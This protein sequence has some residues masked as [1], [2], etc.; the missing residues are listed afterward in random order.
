MWTP[1]S[2]D[3]IRAAVEAGDLTETSRFDAKEALPTGKKTRD[4]ATDV[5][6]M[7][8]DGGTLLYGVGEDENKALRILK[9][10][11]L[12]G[13]SER[14]DQIVRTS[15]VEPP[16]IEVRQIPTTTDPSVGYLVV[17]VPA[18]PRAPHMVVVNKD[19][20][21]YGRSAAGN[22]RLT[23]GEVAR[24]YERR[25]RWEVDRDAMLDEAVGSAPIEPSEEHAYLHLVVRPVT[26][27]EDLFDRARGEQSPERFLDG[28]I[29]RATK[30]EV[31]SGRYSPDLWSNATY[32]RRADGW[33]TSRGLAREWYDLEDPG[34]VLDLE[35]GLDG[36]GRLFCGRAADTY[37]G[38]LLVFETIVAGLATRFLAVM[39][40][41]YAYGAYLGQVDAGLAVTNLRD[42]TSYVLSQRMGL[43]PNPYNKEEY[44]RTAR[45][46][47][48][49]LREQHRDAAREL[50]MPLARALTRESHDPFAE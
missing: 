2:E 30:R 48:S 37:D 25:Q 27:H 5:A 17:S 19:H 42:G 10:F 16:S 20:R 31:F 13:A 3:Q 21:F 7:A 8:N 29:A 9:P 36:R 1:S 45:F 35:V 32:E 23:E 50:V 12:A 24:L 40:G 39:G 28:L 47:A 41:L 14:V 22:I 43:D 6:A 33:A 26:P 11:S 49:M 44:R 46:S 18:S 15:I 34:K 38:R 4:L